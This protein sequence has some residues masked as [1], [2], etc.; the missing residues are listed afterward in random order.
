MYHIYISVYC[1][2]KVVNHTKDVNQIFSQGKFNS[3]TFNFPPLYPH[4]IH[5]LHGIIHVRTL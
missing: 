2:C 4:F 5:S 3:S 1:D